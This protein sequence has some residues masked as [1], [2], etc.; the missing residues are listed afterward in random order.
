MDDDI[1]A[2]LEKQHYHVVGQ[3]SGVKLC[4][5]LGEKLLRARPCY[6]ES[7]YGIESHR[8]LQMSPAVNNCTQTCLFCW[9][10]QGLL[11][12]DIPQEDDPEDILQ[13]AIEGQRKLTTGYKG[14]TRCSTEMWKEAQDLTNVAIS[15]SGEP[16]M[17]S[18][19]GEFIEA[20]HKRNMTTFLVTNGTMPEVLENLDPLP[21]QLYVTVA[22]PNEEIYKKLC[23]PLQRDGWERLNRTLELLPSLGTRTVIRHTLVDGWNLGWEKEYARL[24][25]R[26]NPLFIEPKGYVFV[27]YSRERMHNHNMP[28]QDKIMEFSLKLA[29]E[30]GRKVLAEQRPSR[31][32]LIGADGSKMKIRGE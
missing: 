6:K 20:C 26:A 28:S 27:G 16:T 14:D 24:D 2:I 13:G 17:Y 12:N 25:D 31:V 10:Y 21:T 4:H 1:K 11:E 8:C 23:V 3:H 19:L 15:L 22:A 5:W 30:T 9:R 32:T 18:K 29:A 7:F